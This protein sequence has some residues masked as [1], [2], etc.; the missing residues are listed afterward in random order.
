MSKRFLAFLCRV[1]P[2]CNVARRFPD[3][4]FAKGLA[5]AEQNCPACRA[6]KE[7]YGKSAQGQV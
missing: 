1:C 5:K 7:I 2:A 3:S 4:N 6:Y